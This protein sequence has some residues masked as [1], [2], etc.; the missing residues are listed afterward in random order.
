[1]IE[2]TNV[3]TIL[4]QLN[5]SIKNK[6]SFSLCRWG[7]GTLKAVCAFFNHETEQLLEISK[8]EGIPLEVFEK[9]IEY[10]KTSAN[11]CDYIDSPE[12]YFNGEFWGRTKKI[13]KKKISEQTYLKLKNW[14][15][16]YNSIGI[17]NTNY[18]NPEINFLMCLA[19]FGSKSLPDLLK[20]KKICWITDR[21]D[22]N[23]KL[24]NFNIEILSISHKFENQYQNSFLKVI[25]KIENDANKYDLWLISAG[26]L[27][28]MY[29][30]LIKFQGGRALDVGSLVDFWCDGI[31]PS[32]LKPYMTTT[33]HNPLKLVLTNTGREFNKFI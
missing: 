11:I 12:V 26:E 21:T 16:T 5:S 25:N 18:C 3:L 30:G 29:P 20:N 10:W 6:N 24:P 14:R 22:V 23:K 28:R 27:G 33:I 2:I 4:N 17:T 19:K 9:V 8:Q 31:M 15:Q 13:G 7:D 32:R 1:M